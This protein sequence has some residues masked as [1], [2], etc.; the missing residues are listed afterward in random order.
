MWDLSGRLVRESPHAH[1]GTVRAI[2]RQTEATDPLMFTA[3][4]DGIVRCWGSD[5]SPM[6]SRR[7]ENHTRHDRCE[8]EPVLHVVAP[9]IPRARD[10]HAGVVTA[11]V[12]SA[13]AADDLLSTGGD[14]VLRLW[15]I[16]E[17]ALANVDFATVETLIKMIVPLDTGRFAAIGADGRVAIWTYGEGLNLLRWLP[18]TN[19]TG[20][21][22]VTTRDGPTLVVVSDEGGIETW[23]ATEEPQRLWR[24]TAHLPGSALVAAAP[25][26]TD[27][28]IVTAGPEGRIRGWTYTGEPAQL[29]V[30]VP[31]SVRV[32]A[33]ELVTWS[34]SP[35]AVVGC[36]DG[37]LRSW[38]ADSSRAP[39]TGQA[40]AGAVRGVATLSSGD[41]PAIIT[42]GDDAWVRSWSVRDGERRFAFRTYEAASVVAALTRR[43]FAIGHVAGGIVLAHDTH[44]GE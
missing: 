3:G 27:I 12:G 20:G 1:A 13:R 5:L 25:G 29:D 22:A 17:D 24:A 31:D 32:W 21:A 44:V 37:Q 26:I 34:G 14:R 41:A 36:S 43:R 35:M 15:R 9:M 40:H 4:A 10:A 2:V 18:V 11:L 8:Q 28:P 6:R 38:F 33:L 42:V 23:T 30:T 7:S 16:T 39:I 19:V